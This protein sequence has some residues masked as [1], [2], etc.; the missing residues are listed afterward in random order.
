MA[1]LQLIECLKKIEGRFVWLNISPNSNCGLTIGYGFL[2]K[3]IDDR[4]IKFYPVD[5]NC[6][7]YAHFL[8]S[9]NDIDGLCWKGPYI[10]RYR[11][12]ANATNLN[13]KPQILKEKEEKLTNISKIKPNIQKAFKD[14]KE[15]LKAVDQYLI[16]LQ[17]FYK[18]IDY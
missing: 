1:D 10:D 7:V 15:E 13:V 18:E 2:T 4:L 3:V 5:Q 11:L 6:K 16:N 17:D 9:I 14:F 12:K 8:I